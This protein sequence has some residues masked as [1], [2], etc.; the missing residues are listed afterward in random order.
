MRHNKEII[1]SHLPNI[2]HEHTLG[3]QTFISSQDKL[4][5]SSHMYLYSEEIN[6]CSY[7]Q[8]ETQQHFFVLT[9]VDDNLNALR[10]RK[11]TWLHFSREKAGTSAW[12][13]LTNISESVSL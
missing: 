10:K 12:H 11:F 9:K 13:Y 4:S 3:K 8:S 7:I 1:S 5:P 2:S 6:W